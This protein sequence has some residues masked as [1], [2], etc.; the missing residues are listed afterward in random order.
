MNLL[1]FARMCWQLKDYNSK[2]S[3]VHIINILKGHI[4]P[5]S[6]I[7]RRRSL[8]SGLFLSIQKKFHHN[9][10]SRNPKVH[11][12][13]PLGIFLYM[14]LWCSV[15]TWVLCYYMESLLLVLRG[16]LHSGDTEDQNWDHSIPNAFIQ[17]VH[18]NIRIH[19]VLYI[20]V[21][22]IYLPLKYHK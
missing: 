1:N 19:W 10:H 14:F 12:C 9:Y 6:N 4:L 18:C 7:W 16:R 15:L 2:G 21:P 5:Y 20:F 17:Q 13:Y 8:K 22:V 3:S 11:I